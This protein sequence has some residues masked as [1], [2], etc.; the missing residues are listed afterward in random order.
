MRIPPEDESSEARARQQAR[1]DRYAAVAGERL[2]AARDCQFSLLPYEELV[3]TAALWYEA[4][5]EALLDG[6]YTSLDTLVRNQARVAAAQGFELAD[7]LELLRLCRQAAIEKEGWKE[8]QFADVDGVIDDALASLRP[9]VAWAI[10]EG[11]NYLSGKSRAD[12]EQEER[13]AAAQ[14]AQP[15][16]ERRTHRR[17]KLRLPIRVRGLLSRGP[18]D[19]ITR[20]ENLAKGGLYFLS[21]HAYFKRMKL[22]VTYP[23]WE[24]PGAINQ[25]Y[26]AE[27]VRIDELG[28]TRGVAVKFLVSLGKRAPRP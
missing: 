16:R 2:R 14:A 8:D 17:N 19:E 21:H 20:T 3:R 11:L 23:Y 12:R 18:V 27:V 7:L 13:Q 9:Q 5:A 1:R 22:L 6:N 24:T 10:P 15:G 25:E 4:C 26:P 28:E